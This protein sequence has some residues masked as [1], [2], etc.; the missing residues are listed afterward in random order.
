ME[1]KIKYMGIVESA[2]I[3]YASPKYPEFKNPTCWAN[4]KLGSSCG[5][6]MGNIHIS[7]PPKWYD[8]IMDH[9]LNVTIEIGDKIGY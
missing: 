8:I 6:D 3:Y 4:V 5:Q 7:L 1:S 2:N 9:K